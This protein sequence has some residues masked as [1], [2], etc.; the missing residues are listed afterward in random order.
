MVDHRTRSALA[1]VELGWRGEG[2]TLWLAVPSNTRSAALRGDKSGDP[3]SRYVHVDILHTIRC[4][5]AFPPTCRRMLKHENNVV[6]CDMSFSSRLWTA[7]ESTSIGSRSD[8]SSL[9]ARLACPLHI[10]PHRGVRAICRLWT[11]TPSTRAA[12]NQPSSNPPSSGGPP[13]VRSQLRSS[14][15]AAFNGS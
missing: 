11:A 10:L 5:S 12:M 14:V 9:L 6:A 3:A 2:A 13:S 7:A 8:R 4:V 1:R 15:V